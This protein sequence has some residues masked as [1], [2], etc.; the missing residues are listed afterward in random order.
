MAD[1]RTLLRRDRPPD[2]PKQW[3]GR[4]IRTD[5]GAYVAGAVTIAEGDFVGH[6]QAQATA[7]RAVAV[8]EAVQG[9]AI[10]TGDGTAVV[11][12][13]V[14]LYRGRG[15]WSE[16]DYRAALENYLDWVT[17]QTGKVVLR[18]IKRRGQQAVELSLDEVYVPLAAE[19]LPNA[20]AQ[21]RR[22]LGR[23]GAAEEP[24]APRQI[25][26]RELL[27]QGNRLAVIGAPG[28]GKTT[29]LQHIAWT[30][31]EALRTGRPELAA[32]R[33][34]LSGDLSTIITCWS[35]RRP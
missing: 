25:S 1:G 17:A 16:A 12:H 35:A 6:N 23:G 20:R 11:G 8:G 30:L 29:V 10:S 2:A 9:S 21:L 15:Q 5:G 31:A 26:M 3:W 22:N 14:N 18:G 4:V 19:P 34:G 32:E 13:I 27:A 24:E 33:L 7:P 28:C